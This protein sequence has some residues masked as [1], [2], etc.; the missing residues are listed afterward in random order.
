MSG[1][2]FI[3]IA[4]RTKRYFRRFAAIHFCNPAFRR[5]QFSITLS[6]RVSH[7]I[8]TPAISAF[9]IRTRSV[10]FI[11]CEHDWLTSFDESH[12][13]LNRG[14]TA[15]Y[16]IYARSRPN[17]SSDFVF[18]HNSNVTIA[19]KNWRGSL[20]VNFVGRNW[21]TEKLTA[22]ERFRVSNF[23]FFH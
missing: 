19:I 18:L 2:L 17:R 13:V 1:T 20:W 11:V 23:L 21:E 6:R 15:S 22:T 8:S 14:L 9:S 4:E 16:V 5:S 10:K 7:L 3:L 12:R